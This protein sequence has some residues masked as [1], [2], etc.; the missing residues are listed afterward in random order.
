MSEVVFEVYRER[1]REF[2]D[3]MRL[4][5]DDIR[6]YASAVALLAVHS[7]ISYNDALLIKLTGVRPKG[8]NHNSVIHSAK[9]ACEKANVDPA[10]IK[11][12]E[13]LLGAKTEVSYGDHKV[14]TEYAQTLNI[15]AERFQAWVERNFAGK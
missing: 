2:A 14:G 1:A 5:N 8:D 7:A 15:A 13:K 3:A 9:R 10:G 11:H 12:L 6:S 4:C